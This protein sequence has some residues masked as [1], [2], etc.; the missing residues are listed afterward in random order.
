MRAMNLANRK[1][2]AKEAKKKIDTEENDF[3]VLETNEVM[4]RKRIHEN[5]ENLDE[6]EKETRLIEERLCQKQAALCLMTSEHLIQMDVVTSK[7]HNEKYLAFRMSY[8]SR[9]EALDFKIKFLGSRRILLK[10]S[11]IVVLLVHLSLV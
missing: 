9:F 1:E 2:D 7:G 10:S 4:V 5:Q 11:C 6:H 8:A 3:I